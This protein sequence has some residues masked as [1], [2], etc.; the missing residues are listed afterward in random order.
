[1]KTTDLCDAHPDAV[2]VAEPV[3]RDF[4]G[5][6]AFHGPVATLRVRDD[7]SLVRAA[8]S[9][10]GLG[11]VLVVDGGG[12]T[13]CALL[14]DRLAA[15]AVAHGWAGVVIFGCVRDAAAL[16]SFP[17]G[18]KALAAHPRKSLKTG[19]GERD[20][21]L[22]LAGVRI[23]PGDHLYA[24]EDGLLVAGRPLGLADGQSAGGV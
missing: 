2:Q 17:L 15:L 1:M 4:G 19:Q 3:F 10:P 12:S 18:V 14:G 24:D 16:G 7:N 13:R 22:E 23:R 9:E 21:T 5:L 20:V 6:R 8:L 11:R